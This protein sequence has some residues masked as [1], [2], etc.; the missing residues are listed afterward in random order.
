MSQTPLLEL[1]ESSP[2]AVIVVD[3][4]GRIR[5]A[6]SRVAEMLGYT[7]GELVGESPDILVPERFKYA[8]ADHTDRFMNDPSPR[9]IGA[10]SE[11]FARRK[12]GSEFAAEISLSPYSAPSGMVVIAAIREVTAKDLQ[13][14]VLES[15]N[16]DLHELLGQARNDI[17]RLLAKAGADAVR[18][19]SLSEIQGL[20]LKESHHRIKNLLAMVTAITSQS[21]R[22]AGSLDE[23]RLAIEGRLAALSRAQDLLLKANDLG[24]PLVD[25]IHSAI[26]PFDSRDGSRFSVQDMP[27]EV[28]PTAIL[29]LTMSLNELCTNAVKYGGLSNA[30]G[31]ID[32]R[33][34]LDEARQL[35][36]LGWIESGGP[37]VQEP[38]RRGFGSRLLG[39]L[40]A[41][42]HGDV[43]LSYPASGFVCELMIPL[44]LLR[45]LPAH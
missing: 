10:G 1:Y 14:S 38:T 22:S 23:G 35:F 40:A 43:R 41:Q 39:G 2:D 21:L 44:P 12:D 11:L 8:Y 4:R 37:T 20:L 5:F 25:I 9:M 13:R 17:S 18:Q 6:N 28:G 42:L 26:E 30:T 24:A 19:E 33:S 34:G 3:R 27:L 31:R 7:P 45:A 32:I 16:I 36:T 29:P 15:E